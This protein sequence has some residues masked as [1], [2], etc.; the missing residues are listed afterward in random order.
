ME[1][2]ARDA[3]VSLGNSL[4][5]RRLKDFSS[6]FCSQLPVNLRYPM[7]HRLAPLSLLRLL[8]A[9]CKKAIDM[10]SF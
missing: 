2:L 6:N 7:Q 10:L 9:Y 4:Q 3:F 5:C 1:D 8:L